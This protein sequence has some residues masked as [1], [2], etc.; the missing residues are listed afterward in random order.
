MATDLSRNQPG[1]SEWDHVE[2][3]W[4]LVER[5]LLS[6][7]F[8][9]FL[10]IIGFSMQVALNFFINSAGSG[11]SV[12]GAS[13]VVLRG[14]E[15]AGGFRHPGLAEVGI[16][17]AVDLTNIYWGGNHRQRLLTACEQQSPGLGP[18]AHIV[19]N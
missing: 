11:P 8:W 2:R 15:P 5:L 7:R 10:A 17:V 6:Q 9:L 12:G 1:V 14:Y 16:V 13:Q 4:A 18:K 3:A 19:R